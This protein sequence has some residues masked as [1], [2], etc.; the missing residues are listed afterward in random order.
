MKDGTYVVIQ[1]FMLTELGLK[2]NELIVYAT[3]Y[4]YTQ[5]GEHWFYG[6][7]GHLAEWCGATKGTVGNCLKSLVEK[8]YVERREHIEQGQVKIEYRVTK[9]V[10]PPHKN[11][12]TPHTKFNPNNN[13]EEQHNN[14]KQYMGKPKKSGFTP[15]TREQVREYVK[16][17]GYHFDADHFFDYY[18][19]SDWHLQGGKRITR[20]K[21]CCV[22]WE[23]N[24]NPKDISEQD[25]LDLGLDRQGRADSSDPYATVYE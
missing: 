22:T 1:S 12:D 11:C 25:R 2:G 9:N 10:T 13:K 17:R 20:W 7:K 21:Q 18:S 23:R 24:A 14:N 4:G 16:E 5:D 8:G 6:T 15:P 3:I 19:A